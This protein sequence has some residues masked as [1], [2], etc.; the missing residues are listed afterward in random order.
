MYYDGD[1]AAHHC[2]AG[3]AASCRARHAA[4]SSR[5]I[6]DPV[7]VGAPA[8]VALLFPGALIQER[9]PGAVPNQLF[10]MRNR[11]TT[12]RSTPSTGNGAGVRRTAADQRRGDVLGDRKRRPLLIGRAKR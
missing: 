4:L 9:V 1:C 2:G 7:D 8:A 3:A 10:I 6:V 11:K 12:E 5:G